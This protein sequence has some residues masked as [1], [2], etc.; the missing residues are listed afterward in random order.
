M[1]TKDYADYPV[2]G[3]DAKSVEHLETAL[4]EF[5]CYIR[6]PVA[7]VTTALEHAP[8]MVMG[9]V[10]MA[11]L[12]LLG[13]EPEGLPVA[14]QALQQAIAL[15]ASKRE[16]CHIE[17]V[18]LLTEGRWRDAA[19]VLEDLSID[20]PRDA[21]AL[22]AGH[23]IDFLA[24]DARMLRDRIAR[25][26][27]F[28]SDG[29]PGYHAVL[30]MHAFGLEETGDYRQAEVQ[31]RRGVELEP[32]DG[33]SQHAVAHV[34]EMQNRQRDGIAWMRANPE[35]WSHE[36][37]FCVHN[38]WHLALYHLDLGEIDEVLALYDGPVYGK[39]SP[40]VL[41]MIDAS[42]MLWRLTLRGVNVGSRWEPLAANWEKVATAGNY[43]FNDMHAMMAF[44]GAGRGKAADAVLA[45][46][47]SALQQTGDNAAFTREVGSAA[48]RAIK[49][50]GDGNFAETVRLLRPIRST[51]QRFGGSHAQRDL[52]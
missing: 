11:Y 20:Y 18:R 47:A 24:G 38:W 19:R 37:F 50:F 1:Q 33:W 22:Q 32:R 34:M 52:L 36:S 23:V 2:S 42:A 9:H 41:E 45:T 40:L 35:A 6:D 10:L 25:A 7:T 17:A 16:R 31:G 26:L 3:A 39:Q 4:H 8:E 27:P 5:R 44:V 28:W 43:A 21:L 15:P 12:H 13:T 51:A 30:G 49:A 48:T 29:M 14:R 46:Q